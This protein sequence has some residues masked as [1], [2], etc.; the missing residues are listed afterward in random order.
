M[1][2]TILSLTYY[3]KGKKMDVII[4]QIQKT[5]EQGRPL[6]VKTGPVATQVLKE[7]QKR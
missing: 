2:A 4:K 3:F 6:V 5:L 1:K 7:I